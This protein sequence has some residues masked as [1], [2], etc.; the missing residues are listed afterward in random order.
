MARRARKRSTGKQVAW[1][2]K[3]AKAAKTCGRR[4][5]GTFKGCMRSHLK[6]KRAR[7]RKRSR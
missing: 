7:G 4:R 6:G 1:R 2:R 3:F 5:S